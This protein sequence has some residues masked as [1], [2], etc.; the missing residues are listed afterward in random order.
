MRSFIA[1][2]L[3]EEDKFRLFRFYKDNV[4]ILGKIKEVEPLNYH[5]TFFFFPSLLPKD[6][7]LLKEQII[8]IKNKIQKRIKIIGF[9]AFPNLLKPRVF[10]F[11]IEKNK[12]M[13]DIFEELKNFIL[14]NSINSKF[15]EPF[16]PH[17]T[18]FRIKYLENLALNKKEFELEVKIKD[19]NLFK[20]VL[21]KEGPKYFKV[22]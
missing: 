8:E 12:W 14:R 2:D 5:I 9:N 4:K 11:E 17:L 20:S 22:I 1:L 18:L 13:I 19:L 6:R 10:F 16:N 15:K 21:T 3:E 7:E